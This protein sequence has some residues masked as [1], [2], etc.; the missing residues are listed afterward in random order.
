[1]F[2]VAILQKRS[3][4]EQID[5]NIETIIMA[6]E[7]PNSHVV[8]ETSPM[9][10]DAFAPRPGVIS[11]NIADVTFLGGQGLTVGAHA[12]SNEV[13]GNG[14][15]S[16]AVRNDVERTSQGV[17]TI[18]HGVSA[19]GN[20]FHGDSLDIIVQRTQADVADCG[21]IVGNSGQNA[22]GGALDGSR[23]GG[24]VNLFACIVLGFHTGQLDESA[25]GAGA[26]LTGNHEELIK[27]L[28]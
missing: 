28:D 7:E 27:R 15:G 9:A 10:P 21:L 17:S 5:K 2:K 26:I 20:A 19:G 6:M 4:N 11:A 18:L 12:V 16:F 22:V 14:V 13:H 23:L 1:M 25:A 3:I 8:D 24:V